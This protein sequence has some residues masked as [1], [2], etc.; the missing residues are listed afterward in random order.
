MADSY[1]EIYNLPFNMSTFSRVWGVKTPDEARF[2]IERLP[3]RFIYDNNYFNDCFQS[4]PICGYTRMVENMLDGI[5]V[6]TGAEFKDVDRSRFARVIYTGPV[7]EYFDFSLG[8]L[9]WRTV[10]FE[11]ELV[12][13]VMFGGRLGTY[14]YYDM[15]SCI[16]VALAAVLG[17][18]VVLHG[19][20]Y[21]D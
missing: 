16:A 9:E 19:L 12:E 8:N 20:R 11:D 14:R 10:R 13:G 4:I 1:G 21:Q 3:V 18:G 2:I 6:R 17:I 7:D 15:A 5:E